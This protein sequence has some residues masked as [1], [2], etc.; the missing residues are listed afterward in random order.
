MST[1]SEVLIAIKAFNRRFERLE[2]GLYSQ[3]LFAL[4]ALMRVDL[5]KAI[6]KSQGLNPREWYKV[7][8]LPNEIEL[9]GEAETMF[10]NYLELLRMNFGIRAGNMDTFVQV[11]QVLLGLHGLLP[12]CSLS[13]EVRKDAELT[14][15]ALCVQLAI[16]NELDAE[17]VQNRFHSLPDD[18]L[19]T[20][21]ARALANSFFEQLDIAF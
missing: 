11:R 21:A 19:L 14:L 20:Q 16:D 2:K 8:E 18:L 1:L 10:Q 5:T 7:E 17:E 4:E 12:I 3:D 9:T 15:R 6:A 13:T